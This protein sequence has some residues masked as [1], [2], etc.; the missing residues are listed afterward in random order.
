MH[1]LRYPCTT[2]VNQDHLSAFVAC[3]L[4]PLDICVGVRPGI[5]EVHRRIVTKSI[6][7]LLKQDILDAAGPL[8]VCGDQESGCEAAIHAMCQIFTG[9][10]T[11][12]ALLVD[13]TNAFNSINWQA[14]LHNISNRCPPM[15]QVLFNTYQAPVCCLIQG[16][17]EIFSSEGT[18]QKDPSLWRCMPSLSDL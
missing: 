15:A 1:N 5:G 18:T 17:G 6:L 11:E 10:E 13:A 9:E 2:C 8:Q 14:A 7:I 12:G 16:G 4:I 3:R